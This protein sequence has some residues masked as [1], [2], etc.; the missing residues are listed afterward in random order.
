[1]EGFGQAWAILWDA[2]PIPKSY[3]CDICQSATFKINQEKSRDINCKGRNKRDTAITETKRTGTGG[4]QSAY[5][6]TQDSIPSIRNTIN[7]CAP[8][9]SDNQVKWIRSLRVMIKIDQRKK[10]KYDYTYKDRV[11]NQKITTKGQA[12]SRH[13]YSPQMFTESIPGL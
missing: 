9:K 2:D 8:K 11:S 7:T 12:Q 6:Q 4:A 13:R 3:L 5:A 10:W 1:M